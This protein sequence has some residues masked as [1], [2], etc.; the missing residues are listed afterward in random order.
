MHRTDRPTSGFFIIASDDQEILGAISRCG[1]IL[2]DGTSSSKI[3]R[4]APQYL[5]Q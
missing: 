5:V 4:A 2:P 1:K 3:I